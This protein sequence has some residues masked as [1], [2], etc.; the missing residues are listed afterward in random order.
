MNEGV[1]VKA[2]E[3]FDSECNC[4]Q[5]VFKAVV[6]HTGINIGRATDIAAGFGE[7]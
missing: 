7:G 5:A 2:A 4:A 3:L 6:E 1:V